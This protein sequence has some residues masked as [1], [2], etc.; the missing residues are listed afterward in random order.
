MDPPLRGRRVQ[1]WELGL[2]GPESYLKAG[3][4][5]FLPLGIASVASE[6]AAGPGGDSE[7]D[8]WESG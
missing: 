1:P 4:G 8:A 5:D 2:P 6:A 3:M 7:T